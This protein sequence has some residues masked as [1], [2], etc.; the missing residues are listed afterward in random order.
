MQRAHDMLQLELDTS[1]PEVFVDTIEI[2]DDGPTTVATVTLSRRSESL[3][4]RDL[5]GLD[6]WY[7]VSVTRSG[8][9]N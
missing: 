3:V 2:D 8:P 4:L 7:D 6:S 9:V 1:D 5:F